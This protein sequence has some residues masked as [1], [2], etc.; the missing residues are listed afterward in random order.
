MGGLRGW[1]NWGHVALCNSPP[2]TACQ[3]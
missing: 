2:E 3:G 1:L